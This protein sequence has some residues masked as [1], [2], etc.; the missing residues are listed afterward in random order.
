MRKIFK[1][2]FKIK[3]IQEI[4]ISGFRKILKISEQNEKLYLWCLVETLDKDIT[5][6]KV[7]IFG[8]G[9]EINFETPIHSYLDT[10]LMTDGLVW[11][12]FIN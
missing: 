12:I 1:Y 7:S 5:P 2:E 11:H 10:I 8:T 3:D 4:E 9:Q 6:L